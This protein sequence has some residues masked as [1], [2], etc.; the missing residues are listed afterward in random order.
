MDARR[1]S[2]VPTDL[3]VGE[4]CWRWVEGALR[5]EDP[6]D[7]SELMQIDFGE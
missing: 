2:G 5:K 3:S 6:T 1:S 4:G 7:L